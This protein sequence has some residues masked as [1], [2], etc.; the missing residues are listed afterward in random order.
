MPPSTCSTRYATIPPLSITGILA[1]ATRSAAKL[2]G[3][4]RGIGYLTSCTGDYY[5]YNKLDTDHQKWDNLSADRTFGIKYKAFVSSQPQ[6]NLNGGF[7]V[8]TVNGPGHVRFL[9]LACAA[10]S[11]AAFEHHPSEVISRYAHAMALHSA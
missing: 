3:S 5:F 2:L 8:N 10:D 6:V 11:P 7:S 1:N 4:L 9:W